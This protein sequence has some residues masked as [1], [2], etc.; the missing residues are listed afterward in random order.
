MNLSYTEIIEHCVLFSYE[1]GPKWRREVWQ[2]GECYYKCIWFYN[3][4]G[5]LPN[6]IQKVKN[7]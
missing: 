7:V 5:S 1:E 3:N 4:D 2:D 6:T